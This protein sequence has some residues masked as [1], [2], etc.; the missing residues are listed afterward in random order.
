MADETE[1]VIYTDP[2]NLRKELEMH[3]D[4]VLG[5]AL[6]NFGH[7]ETRRDVKKAQAHM[8]AILACL[9]AADPR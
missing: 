4:I 2:F 8:T 3:R 9:D 7:H 1:G 5:F 6:C